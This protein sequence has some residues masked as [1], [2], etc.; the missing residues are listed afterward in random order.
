MA[1]AR[2]CDDCYFRQRALCALARTEPCA[3]FRPSVDG[4]LSPPPQAPLIPPTVTTTEQA[5]VPVVAAR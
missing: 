4:R 3:T 5:A 2:S 1:Q